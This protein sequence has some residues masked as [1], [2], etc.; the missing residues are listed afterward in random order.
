MIGTNLTN[1]LKPD[2]ISVGS[3][4]DVLG[5]VHQPNCGIGGRTGGLGYGGGGFGIG[6]L[7][8]GKGLGSGGM[9]SG[10][11]SGLGFHLMIVCSPLIPAMTKPFLFRPSRRCKGR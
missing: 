7:G 10:L 1:V 9:G 2:R 6:G 11:G 3:S 5:G 4:R 8:E